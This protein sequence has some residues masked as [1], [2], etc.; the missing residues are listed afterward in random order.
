MSVPERGKPVVELVLARGQ[1]GRKNTTPSL[2]KASKAPTVPLHSTRRGAPPNFDPE[3]D[4]YR[5]PRAS[6]NPFHSRPNLFTPRH[7]A[8]QSI[9]SKD[10]SSHS[11]SQSPSSTSR[12]PS[13]PSRPKS[14]SKQESDLQLSNVAVD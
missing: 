12:A 10:S 6:A 3:I 13:S 8:Q 14:P 7:E 2:D 4:A 11:Q 5:T 1:N 9:N